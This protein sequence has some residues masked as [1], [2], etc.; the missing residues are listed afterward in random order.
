[1]L[2]YNLYTLDFIVYSVLYTVSKSGIALNKDDIHMNV[3]IYMW[4]MASWLDR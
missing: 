2:F 1:M 3:S 4:Y